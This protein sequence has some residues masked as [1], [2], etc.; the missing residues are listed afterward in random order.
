MIV[1]IT[2][3]FIPQ[4]HKELQ[5]QKTRAIMRKKKEKKKENQCY[6]II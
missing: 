5:L 3:K 4:K 2:S 1:I 6:E